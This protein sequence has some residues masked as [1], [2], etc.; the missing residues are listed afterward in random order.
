MP[1]IQSWECWKNCSSTGVVCTGLSEREMCSWAISSC[2]G[3]YM[4]NTL[5][6]TNILKYEHKHMYYEWQIERHMCV[7]CKF[8]CMKGTRY[9]SIT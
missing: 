8:H 4:L 2:F 3:D 1:T 7:Y 9:D 6:W 5:L